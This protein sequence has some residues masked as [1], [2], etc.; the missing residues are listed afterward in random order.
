METMIS[1]D[2]LYSLQIMYFLGKVK[3]GYGSEYNT[4]YMVQ[5]LATVL[6]VL[7][8]QGC[9]NYL[10]TVVCIETIVSDHPVFLA[11]LH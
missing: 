4:P 11:E 7:M 9:F 6:E 2:F 10:R 5:A 8:G 1:H 3:A